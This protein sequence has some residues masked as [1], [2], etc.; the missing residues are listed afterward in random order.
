[1]KPNQTKRSFCTEK[2][3]Q[4][5]IYRKE[6]IKT[7]LFEHYTQTAFYWYLDILFLFFHPKNKKMWEKNF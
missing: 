3:K 7:L 5:Q 6:K 2:K 4:P 1:M